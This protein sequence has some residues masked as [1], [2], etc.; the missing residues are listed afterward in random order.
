MQGFAR[1]NEDTVSPK[2][3]TPQKDEEIVEDR[4]RTA[5]QANKKA[6]A[7]AILLLLSFSL[8]FDRRS[9]GQS[10]DCFA[11]RKK[12]LQF[13]MTRDAKKKKKTFL[14]KKKKKK[15]IIYNLK[16]SILIY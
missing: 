9:F 2:S 13:S 4:K 14:I 8:N 5:A 11:S 15:S 16:K 12:Q 7:L 3:P 6:L 10:K 1:L